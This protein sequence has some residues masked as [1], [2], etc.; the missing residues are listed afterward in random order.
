MKSLLELVPDHHDLGKKDA[1]FVFV[2]QM[3]D[4]PFFGSNDKE[5]VDDIF[6]GT[7]R[8]ALRAL[9]MIGPFRAEISLE[10]DRRNERLIVAH[11]TWGLIYLNN[12]CVLGFSHDTRVSNAAFRSLF[13]WPELH[14]Y[15][16][17][18]WD[19]IEKSISSWTVDQWVCFFKTRLLK[20]S[21]LIA[22]KIEEKKI[23]ISK[24]ENDRMIILNGVIESLSV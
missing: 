16:V 20:K 8:N 7:H 21:E 22:S 5:I 18:N 9:T 11:R 12:N 14:N 13:D 17:E 24:L 2:P 19:P 15:P 3:L 4:W 6:V 23:E 1:G 10:V